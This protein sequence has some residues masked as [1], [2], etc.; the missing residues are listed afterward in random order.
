MR[1]LLS[2]STVLLWLV[3]ASG[4]NAMS[5]VSAFDFE[6]PSMDGKPLKMAAFKGKPVLLVN[7]ASQCGYTP[8]YE[9]L[10]QLWQSY[11]DRGLVVLG[12]PANDFGA[13]EPGTAQ[14]IKGFCTTNFGIE[15]P[16]TDKYVVIG[17]KAHPLYRWIASELGEGAAPKWN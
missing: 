16:M 12:V 2:L 6:F 11:K 17:P 15:F 5:T 7:T 8:Q 1:W 9:G 3:T 13:Q 4:G 14:E 10:Q